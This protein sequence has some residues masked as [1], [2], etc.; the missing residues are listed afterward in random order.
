MQEARDIELLRQYVRQNSDEAFAALVARYVNMVY[1]AALRKPGASYADEEITQAVFIILAKKADR[2]PEKTILSGWLYQTARLA[3]AN[4]LRTQIRRVRR[5]QEAYMQSLSNE[6]EP[7]IWPQIMPLLEDAMGRLGEKD[8]NAIALRF[9]EGKSFQ[10]IGTAFGARENA[11]KKRVAYALEKLRKYF[12]KC[13]VN[14]T[15]ATLAGAISANSVQAAPAM[16][17]KTATAVALAKGAA[18]STSTLT[19]I[20]GALEVMAWT[21]V[22]MAIVAGAVVLLAT[23]TT[24]VIVEKVI[25]TANAE[26]YF[27]D[28]R[29]TGNFLERIPPYF[30]VRP[31]HFKELKPMGDTNVITSIGTDSRAIGRD[32]DLKTM[33]E[34][35]YSF[36]NTRRIILPAGK[37]PAGH[38]DFLVTVPGALDK[39]QAEIKKRFGYQ[40]HRENRDADVLLLTVRNPNAPGLKR[41]SPLNSRPSRKGF[42]DWTGMSISSLA[43]ELESFLSVQVVD[44]TGLT[45]T[46]DIQLDWQPGSSDAAK[47]KLKQAVSDQLGLELIP[48]NMPIEMLVIEKVK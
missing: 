37:L 18:A 44:Q 35:A 29:Q 28:M 32:S 1:S 2:L 14:S 22:K 5:E 20:K 47:E 16:L 7:E 31:T 11:A 25:S 6:T 39:L 3:A 42:I 26:K 34:Y 10:E 30:I 12:S 38:F 21:K 41:S 23:G 27:V 13:G 33:I 17:A 40:A 8:R 24:T 36:Y 43:S 19:L 46:Y 48:T 4:F 9:F 15:A 45:D